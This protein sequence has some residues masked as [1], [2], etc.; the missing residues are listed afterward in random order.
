M[1]TRIINWRGKIL[2][3]VFLSLVFLIAQGCSANWPSLLKKVKAKYADFEKKITDITIVQEMKMLAGE[4][5]FSSESKLFKKGN[6]FR[7]E[8]K[9]QAPGMPAST[10]AVETVI[11]FDGEDT[12]MIAPVIGKTKLSD[13]EERQYQT[14]K[15]WWKFIPDEGKVIGSERAGKR[16]CFLIEFADGEDSPFD[17]IW[18][19][20]KSLVL[21]KAEGKMPEGQTMQWIN[22][23]FRKIKGGWEHAYKTEVYVDNNLLFRTTVKSLDV[24]KGLSDDLFNPAK[25]QSKGLNLK[26]MLKKLMR[27]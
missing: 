25:T 26:G 21:V 11:I 12:W 1:S 13:K 5:E 27:K 4:R 15:D 3:V 7:M 23:D 18:L 8:A 9:I 6:R 24:N 22:S 19:D 10:G 14:E 20:K 2:P 17:R 16:N